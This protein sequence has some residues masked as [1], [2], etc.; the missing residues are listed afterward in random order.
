VPL[1]LMAIPTQSARARV[2]R[3]E[4][5]AGL[6]AVLCLQPSAASELAAIRGMSSNNSVVGIFRVRCRNQS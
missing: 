1:F 4:R 5:L 2:K 3:A 6:C